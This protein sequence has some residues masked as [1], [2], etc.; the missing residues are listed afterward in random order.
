[1]EGEICPL[2]EIVRIKKKYKVRRYLSFILDY[3]K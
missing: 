1:M 2:R 3:N